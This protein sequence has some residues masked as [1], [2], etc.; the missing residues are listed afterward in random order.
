[1]GKMKYIE[2]TKTVTPKQATPGSV[3]S[4]SS[5][6]FLSDR[7]MYQKYGVKTSPEAYDMN[8]ACVP[9][10]K[11]EGGNL[12][13]VEANIQDRFSLFTQGL[14]PGGESY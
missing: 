7:Q 4:N 9:M 5:D 2:E 3:P 8:D 1:M 12:K 14:K 6:Y 11:Q 13:K 10:T